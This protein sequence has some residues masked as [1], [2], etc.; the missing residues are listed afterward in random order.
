MKNLLVLAVLL[1]FSVVWAKEV[2]WSDGAIPGEDGVYDWNEPGNWEGGA[3]PAKGDIP[4]FRPAGKLLLKAPSK[5]GNTYSFGGLRFESGSTYITTGTYFYMGPSGFDS[6]TIFVETGALASLSNQ[7]DSA[8][9]LKSVVLK[10]GGGKFEAQHVG[11]HSA[12]AEIDVQEGVLGG[13]NV[14]SWRNM[15]SKAYRVRNG[16][17][18]ALP[19]ANWLN[20]VSVGGVTVKPDLHIEAGGIVKAGGKVEVC[21]L[22]GAGEICGYSEGAKNNSWQSIIVYPSEDA[23]FSGQVW[24]CFEVSSTSVGRFILGRADTLAHCYRVT[25]SRIGFVPGLTGA[26]RLGESFSANMY[27]RPE[28]GYPLHLAD[29]NGAPVTVAAQFESA[30]YAANL[31]TTGPGSFY[32]LYASTTFKGNKLQHTGTLG[33]DATST[34]LTLGDGTAANDVDITRFS[35]LDAKSG[36]ITVNNS[37]P[38]TFNGEVVGANKV[39]FLNDVVLGS[40]NLT[41]G[42]GIVGYGDVAIL[43][44]Q[45]QGVFDPIQMKTD[46]KTFTFVGGRCYKDAEPDARQTVSVLP[47]VTVGCLLPDFAGTSKI[48]GG[49]FYLDAYQGLGSK[50]V[51]LLGGRAI[52]VKEQLP[53]SDAAAADPTVLKLNGGS[54]CVRFYDTSSQNKVSLF[55][56]SGTYRVC[57]GEKGGSLRQTGLYNAVYNHSATI[58]PTI[59]SGVESGKDGGLAQ[60]GYAPVSYLKP[61]EFTG[62]FRVVGGYACLPGTV[63][64]PADQPFFGRGD[65]E[66]ANGVIQIIGRTATMSNPLKIATASGATLRYEGGSAIRTCGTYDG[67]TPTGSAAQSVEIGAVERGIGGVLYISD[68]SRNIG[69]DGSSTVKVNGGVAVHPTNGRV[70]QPIVGIKSNVP[71]FL[72]YD[73]TDGFKPL[74]GVKT[75]LA[76]STADDVVEFTSPSGGWT[77]FRKQQTANALFVKPSTTIYLYNT[78]GLTVG[79]GV[80]PAVVL[81]RGGSIS[82]EGQGGVNFGTAE[83]VVICG[84]DNTATA[85]SAPI[86]SANG[87]TYAGFPDF[88]NV[89]DRAKMT[90]SGENTYSGVTRIG[91]LRLFAQGEKC[92]SSGDVYISDGER[93]GGQVRF[94]LAGGTWENNFHVAGWGTP[95]SI[96]DD[97]TSRGAFFFAKSGTVAGNVELTAEAMVC[98]A[99]DATGTISGTVSGDRLRVFDAPGILRLTG[100]NT[101]TGGTEIVASTLELAKGDGAGAGAVVLNNGTL[102]FVNDESIVFSNK[103]E[104]VGRI[105]LC[106][107]GAVKFTDPELAQAL[108]FANL[109]PGAAFD[110]PSLDNASWSVAVD[111]EGLDL[112]GRDATV[113]NVVGAGV[114]RGG[115]LTVTGEINPGGIGA[116]GTLSF[117]QTPILTGATLV[118]ETENGSVDGVVLPG[119]VSISVLK[120]RIVQ[121]GKRVEV[122]SAAI[123]T[124][125]GTLSGKFA[126]VTKPAKRGE[127]YGIVVDKSVVMLDVILPG[128]LLLVR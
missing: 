122:R 91:C 114:V 96:W 29:T 67:F 44:G 34:T 8:Q 13:V 57:V 24:T 3:V 108:P 15:K 77:G 119:D 82:S 89:G 26:I 27:Y 51:E 93:F 117:E 121:L 9:N 6:A 105:E 110:Y 113:V 95:D 42:G 18:L 41:E 111:A 22:T 62:P 17:T 94:N 25:G 115:T 78:A 59:F 49:E 86:K 80:N 104:G 21:N 107:T 76:S 1:S 48:V 63:T 36:A 46:S 102:R 12:F 126:E 100:S 97:R 79:D 125:G 70:L 68:V 127:L 90:V 31:E 55:P 87:M 83:G 60:Y 66:L 88:R 81:M 116:I 74:S 109:G 123:M 47:S 73:A 28:A 69:E 35:K 37:A 11:T 2:V 53:R 61:L 32:T 64:P 75:D 124:C 58:K 112:K 16:A 30:T 103:V 52:V 99:A 10:T 98:V 65:L 39:T 14:A 40:V 43:E 106:G 4:V 7:L 33:N 45:V 84:G 120:L 50:F 38:F 56:D 54:V 118:A 128:T 71:Y 72:G 23:V 19:A 92:F 101:Y 20:T 5:S 85:I